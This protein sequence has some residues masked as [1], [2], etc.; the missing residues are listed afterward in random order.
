MTKQ[1]LN[2]FLVNA[3]RFILQ[4]LAKYFSLYTKKLEIIQLLYNV[5]CGRKFEM[6]DGGLKT[7]YTHKSECVH[8]TRA[9]ETLAYRLI[10][11]NILLITWNP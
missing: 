2:D 4:I 6:Q 11:G 9:I 8:E 1:L 3:A 10:I 7:G 5:Q